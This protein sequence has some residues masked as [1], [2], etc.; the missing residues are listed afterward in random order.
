MNFLAEKVDMIAKEAGMHTRILDSPDFHKH[1]NPRIRLAVKVFEEAHWDLHEAVKGLVH[2]LPPIKAQED[3]NREVGEQCD[4]LMYAELDGSKPRADSQ[5]EKDCEWVK[6]KLMTCRDR[7]Y[8]WAKLS[9]ESPYD[10]LLFDRLIHSMEE[11]GRLFTDRV[12]DNYGKSIRHNGSYIC[13]PRHR[14][15]ATKHFR[16]KEK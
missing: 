1:S 16:K 6:N 7:T 8:P 5:Y 10:I 3:Y 15:G 14:N 13:L 12:F 9:R 11:Q 2:L 4:A